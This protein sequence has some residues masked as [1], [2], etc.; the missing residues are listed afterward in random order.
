MTWLLANTAVVLELSL[1]HL[2]L[3]VPPIVLGFLLAL[4]PGVLAWRWRQLRAVVL[5]AVGLLYIIPSLALFVVL[6]PI[7]GIPIL[8]D[9]NVVVA[10]TL[11]AVA[12]M[13]RTVTDGLSGVDP[14]V[15]R[16][17][18]ALGYSPW[19]RFWTVDLPLAGPVLLAGLRVVAVSTVSLVT[20]GVLVGVDSLGNLFTSGLQRNNI[21]AVTTG[22]VATVVLALLLDLILLV[23]GRLLLPWARTPRGSARAQQPVG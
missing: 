9:L 22:I 23:A 3:A 17:A 16:A 6:P 18:Q 2:R 1:Q 7:L 15:R 12:L 10:L 4:P 13:T 21:A 5:T 20:V 8:S 14:A 11:Y 19:R